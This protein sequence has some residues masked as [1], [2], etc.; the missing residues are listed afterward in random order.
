MYHCCL[1]NYNN[2]ICHN[3]YNDLGQIFIQEIKRKTSCCLS[4]FSYLLKQLFIDLCFTFVAIYLIGVLM[5]LF[6]RHD[7]VYLCMYIIV[8]NVFCQFTIFASKFY[9]SK[10]TSSASHN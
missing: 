10:S 8:M 3:H 1:L 9:T 4:I 6:L 5:I 2:S 7:I